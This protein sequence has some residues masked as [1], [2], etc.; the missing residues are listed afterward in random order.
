MLEHRVSGMGLE[1]ETGTRA[2]GC[3]RHIAVIFWQG[4]SKRTLTQGILDGKTVGDWQLDQEFS[5]NGSRPRLRAA[6][7]SNRSG[8]YHLLDIAVL[9]IPICK[10]RSTETNT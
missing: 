1:K 7:K 4:V 5:S 2:C 10:A 6:S 3:L 8:T 9:H